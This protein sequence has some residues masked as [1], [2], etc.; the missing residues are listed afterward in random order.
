M[1]DRIGADMEVI[2]VETIAIGVIQHPFQ[3]LEAHQSLPVE[4][5]GDV[6][7]GPSGRGVVARPFVVQIPTA[8]I[9]VPVAALGHFVQR[10]VRTIPPLFHEL[11]VRG[12]GFHALEGGGALEADRHPVDDAVVMHKCVFDVGLGVG[13]ERSAATDSRESWMSNQRTTTSS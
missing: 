13:A 6:G 3:R 7:K 10:P 5:V 9:T 1:F 11:G 2:Q 12:L 4:G 8:T